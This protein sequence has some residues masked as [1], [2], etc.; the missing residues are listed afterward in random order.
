MWGKILRGWALAE[1]GQVGEG[2]DQMQAGVSA[3]RTAGGET[4]LPA[5][6]ASLAKAYSDVS[7]T[8]EARNL[9]DEALDLVEKN[10]ERCWEAA[11]YRLKGELL[12]MSEQ[13]AKAHVCFQ[14]A[15]DVARRQNARS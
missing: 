5:P 8:D 7:R 6:L 14:R 3:W 12:L 9:I 15:L 1:E 4:T 11:L 13:E 10:G 2:I